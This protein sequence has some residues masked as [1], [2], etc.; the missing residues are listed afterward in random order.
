MKIKDLL[1]MKLKLLNKY[2]KVVQF[3]F[4]LLNINIFT[5]NLDHRSDMFHMISN[6]SNKIIYLMV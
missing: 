5:Y 2:R 6:I 1:K 3:T 4:F